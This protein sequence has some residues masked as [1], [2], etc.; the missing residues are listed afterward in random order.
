MFI[1]FLVSSI[2]HELVMSCITKKLRGYGFVAMMLQLPIVAIQQSK[3]FRGKTTLRVS[4]N[5]SPTGPER[6]KNMKEQKKRERE[7]WTCLTY[8]IEHIF[9]AVDDLR[10]RL[11]KYTTLKFYTAQLINVSWQM[12]ALYVLV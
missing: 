9:L 5:Y 12:C 1:T 10:S 8:A 4:T 6:I 11:C 7:K 3:Y 2:A